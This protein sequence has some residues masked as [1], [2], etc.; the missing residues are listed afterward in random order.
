MKNYHTV[1]TFPKSNRK[2]VERGKIDT[3]D[4]EIHDSS[5]YWLGTDTSIKNGGL[6]LVL[7]D[8]IK[9]CVCV[10]KCHL[11]ACTSIIF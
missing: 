5:L 3:S 1:E 9:M 11:M 4:I 6:K 8:K 10:C 7:W 2:I